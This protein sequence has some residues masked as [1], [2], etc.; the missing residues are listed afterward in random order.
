LRPEVLTFFGVVRDRD[1]DRL[2]GEFRTP[3]DLGS[4][5]HLHHLQD[6]SMTV[7]AGSTFRRSCK[8]WRFQF[9]W[10]LG[11]FSGSTTNSKNAPEPVLET[12]AG[13]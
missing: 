11:R 8:G 2:E 6:E 3:P 10:P 7:V 5:M 1:G 13:C 12:Q 4:P 9:F